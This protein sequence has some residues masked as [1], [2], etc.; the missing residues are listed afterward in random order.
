MD[1]LKIRVVSTEEA[2]RRIERGE[3]V[4]NYRVIGKYHT[5]NDFWFLKLTDLKLKDVMKSVIIEIL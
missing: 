3:S 5:I 4:D 1:N 2:L